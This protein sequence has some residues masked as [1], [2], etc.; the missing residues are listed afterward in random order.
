MESIIF[1]C[2]ERRCI[3]TDSGLCKIAVFRNSGVEPS[4]S[5]VGEFRCCGCYY[6]YHAKSQLNGGKVSFPQGKTTKVLLSVPLDY[7]CA[8]R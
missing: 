1:D 7:V 6:H 4:S 2:E 3:E 5:N 8:R